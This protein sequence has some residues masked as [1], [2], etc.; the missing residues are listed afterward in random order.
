MQHGDAGDLTAEMMR[1][2]QV[3]DLL[4]S[5]TYMGA[6]GSLLIP[7][8][9]RIPGS[10]KGAG[11]AY[12]G[13]EMTLR[14]I[15]TR[16]TSEVEVGDKIKFYELLPNGK[17]AQNVEDEKEARVRKV[18]SDT[19]LEMSERLDYGYSENEAQCYLISKTSI[20]TSRND[21]ASNRKW[22]LIVQTLECL[23]PVDLMVSKLDELAK[24]KANMEESEIEKPFREWLRTNS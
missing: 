21:H 19:E 4:V 2:P 17:M 3:F 9:L 15:G 20:F 5:L 14:G 1:A 8:P 6:K 18:I 12:F 16:F 11:N 7:F 24:K 22:D 13:D 23:P 10:C